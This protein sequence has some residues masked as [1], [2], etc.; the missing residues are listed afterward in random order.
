MDGSRMKR[1]GD[2]DAAQAQARRVTAFEIRQFVERF[3][4]YGK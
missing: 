3:E 4:R 1:D 2:F